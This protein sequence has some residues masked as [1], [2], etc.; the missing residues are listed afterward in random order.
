MTTT[1]AIELIKSKAQELCPGWAMDDDNSQ[2]VITAAAWLAR[3]G[4][5]GMDLNKGLL[6]VGN[7]GTG[8][9]MLMRIVRAVMRDAYGTQFGI[10]SCQEMVRTFSEEGYDGISDWMNAPHVCF[11]DLGAEQSGAHYAVKTNLMAEVIETRYSN[12]TSGRKCWTHFTTNLGTDKLKDHLGQRAYSRL[13]HMC[14]LLDLGASSSAID[15]RANAA[16]VEIPLV[17]RNADNVYSAIH[18]EVAARLKAMLGKS[19]RLIKADA[20]KPPSREQ[21]MQ[22]LAEG[23]RSLETAEIE[24]FKAKIENR[25][26]DQPAIVNPYLKIVHDELETRKA[27]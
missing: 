12:L 21:D 20:P 7:V 10:R 23:L 24:E 4:R 5:Q 27:S 19:E 13:R 9:T 15:R 8:K 14:N 3:E 22:V 1:E 16:G 17:P 6:I 11:D 26:S 18:P 2:V 25:Y